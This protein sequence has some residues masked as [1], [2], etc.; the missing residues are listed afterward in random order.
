MLVAGLALMIFEKINIWESKVDPTEK[1][2][3][4]TIPEELDYSEIFDDVFSQYTK[5]YEV[6]KVKSINMGSM[7]KVYYQITMINIKDEKKL[8]DEIRIRNGNLEVSIE[9][10]DYKKS[11]L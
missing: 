11:E 3:R 1:I 6:I 10:I 2:V 4:V 5:K 7:F 8:I 9:R